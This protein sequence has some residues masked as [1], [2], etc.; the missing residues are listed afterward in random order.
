[1]WYKVVNPLSLEP[2]CTKK[3]NLISISC[4]N[5]CL[6]ATESYDILLNSL[7]IKDVQYIEFNLFNSWFRTLWCDDGLWIIYVIAF[8][9]PDIPFANLINYLFPSNIYLLGNLFLHCIRCNNETFSSTVMITRIRQIYLNDFLFSVHTFS[10]QKFNYKHVF[11]S[12][13]II[14]C[15]VVNPVSL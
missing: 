4:W 10:F 13:V 1:M 7:D 5:I 11:G 9:M 15:K 8:G 12:Y 6:C 14:W 3:I 2:H